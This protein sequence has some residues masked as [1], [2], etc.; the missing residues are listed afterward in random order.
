MPNMTL[1]FPDKYPKGR[2]ADREFFF[3]VWNSLHPETVC[4]LIKHANEQRFGLEADNVREEVI[5]M[6]EEFANQFNEMPFTSRQKGRMSHLL[7]KKSKVAKPQK[8]RKTY[9]P[10]DFVKK[11]RDN[12][13]RVIEVP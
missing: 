7:K 8:P 1:Y 3:N 13:G 9:E 11:F 10:F 4:R 2:Q 5:E 6:T 12:D